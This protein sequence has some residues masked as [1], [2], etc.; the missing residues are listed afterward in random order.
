MNPADVLAQ[1]TFNG[2]HRIA[3]VSRRPFRQIEVQVLHM[4][5]AIHLRTEI[6]DGERV[7]RAIPHVAAHDVAAHTSA[8]EMDRVVVRR[9]ILGGSATD[10][11]DV[12]G[13]YVDGVP[14]SVS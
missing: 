7:A 10:E 3:A 2:E 13:S 14:V 6:M 4:L 8:A 12:D 9:A 5:E 11:I 1:G